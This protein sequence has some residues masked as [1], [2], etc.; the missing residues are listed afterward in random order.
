MA[1]FKEVVNSSPNSH[2]ILATGTNIVGNISA[3]EDFRID[4]IV[5]GNIS[6]KGKII[7][8]TTSTITGDITC[9]NIEVLGKVKGNISCYDLAILRANAILDGDLKTKIIEIEPGAK[10]TGTCS[11]MNE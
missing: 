1:K 7:V 6:C 4:G 8:A 9:A 11:M 5:E 10:F 3:E 2:S